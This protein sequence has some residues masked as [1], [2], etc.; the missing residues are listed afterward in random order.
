MKP[1]IDNTITIT[2]I[3]GYS[4]T[5]LE[6][7]TK[8]FVADAACS[9]VWVNRNPRQIRR[10]GVYG[11]TPDDVCNTVRIEKYPSPVLIGIVTTSPPYV[12]I[13][14]LKVAKKW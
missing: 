1:S 12:L 13:S 14:I 11:S 9:G 2:L 6:P 5:I 8:K 10:A 3:G 4:Q 7:A